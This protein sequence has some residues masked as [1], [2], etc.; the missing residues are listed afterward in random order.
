MDAITVTSSEGLRNLFAMVGPL[1]HAWL[2]KTPL[3]VPHA[4][5][6]EQAQALGLAGVIAT[7]PGDDGLVS[8]LI[9]HFS[10]FSGPHVE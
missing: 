10:G 4:R 9:N 8:G 1:G 6:A 5:I 3:F 2:R 7:G